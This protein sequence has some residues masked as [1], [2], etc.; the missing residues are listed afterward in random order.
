[1]EA[2]IFLFKYFFD[3]VLFIVDWVENLS[4]A[5]LDFAALYVSIKLKTN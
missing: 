1:M 3:V 4:Q 5:R 2:Q